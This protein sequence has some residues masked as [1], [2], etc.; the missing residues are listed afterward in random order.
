MLLLPSVSPTIPR[1]SSILSPHIYPLS[2]RLLLL[3]SPDNSLSRSIFSPTLHNLFPLLRSSPL[4]RFL[5]HLLPPRTSPSTF[6]LSC[7][8]LLSRSTPPIPASSPP[9]LSSL[10]LLSSFL[11]LP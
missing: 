3:P 1:S 5:S 10:S 2:S 9:H 8:P 7:N 6:L 4:S 11:L